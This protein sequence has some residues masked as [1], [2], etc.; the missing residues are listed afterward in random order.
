M[1]H[2]VLSQVSKH[3]ASCNILS[4]AQHG[5]RR[6][7]STTTQLTSTLHDWSSTIQKRSQVD[8]VFLDFQKAFDRVPHQ[9]LC[10]KLRYYGITGDTLN[11]IMSFLTNRQQ[12]VV[13]DGSKSTW[14]NVTSGVPQDD[15]D[16]IENET[17]DFDLSLSPQES[18]PGPQKADA[19]DDVCEDEEDEV[20]M[21]P[22]GFK[23]QCVAT[24]AE[25]AIAE[26]KSVSPPSAAQFALIF[27]EACSVALEFEKMSSKASSSSSAHSSSSGSGSSEV[28]DARGSKAA[29]DLSRVQGTDCNTE[30]SE[31]EEGLAHKEG[32]SNKSELEH[33][34]REV[35]RDIR[36][37]MRRA[38]YT[39]KTNQP[40]PYPTKP[41]SPMKRE[42]QREMQ[43]PSTKLFRPHPPQ[44]H[45]PSNG[46]GSML[47]M[48]R[49]RRPTALPRPA[50][51]GTQ[52][53]GSRNPTSHT[54]SDGPGS[55]I[56]VSHAHTSPA[57]RPASSRMSGLKK[58]GFS[59]TS[60]AGTKNNAGT[61]SKTNVQPKPATNKPSGLKAPGKK[62]SLMKPS[63][64][65]RPGQRNGAAHS[66]QTAGGAGVSK[67][68]PMRATMSF[69][70]GSSVAVAAA[71][72]RG[73]DPKKTTPPSQISA[74]TGKRKLATP[75][76]V[77]P[78]AATPCTP[79]CQEKKVVPKRLLSSG[80]TAPATPKRG[81]VT[82]RRST[83][84]IPRPSTPVQASKPHTRHSSITTPL[85]A[86]RPA[87]ARRMSA[88]P[89][90]G[91]RPDS[92]LKRCGST[93][94]IGSSVPRPASAQPVLGENLMISPL[95]LSP[96]MSP[97][98]FQL[99]P[100]P[101]EG[102]T[103]ET[104]QTSAPP[105]QSTSPECTI[106]TT[107]TPTPANVLRS[108]TNVQESETETNLVK[109][110]TPRN[111]PAVGLLV[112]F[113]SAT[114]KEKKGVKRP[115]QLAETADKENLITF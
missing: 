93:S 45:A 33:F 76:A 66:S 99:S 114:P 70:T 77:T 41:P 1:E 7:L 36:C 101:A 21:G 60:N 34:K 11:W 38:T 40:S 68:Q 82:P 69:G 80:S 43:P 91:R 62:L 13:V 103:K 49:L 18:H 31:T 22:V 104:T 83:S 73:K 29:T 79:V 47:P 28:K 90:P 59:K 111:A 94:K 55:Q 46:R 14:K 25:L 56:P 20:F 19:E 96:L 10:T 115:Q 86:A 87:S 44:T 4:D 88:I 16:L 64:I 32:T 5:F 37:P 102:V 100:E 9:R 30:P 24:N 75:R 89:T 105:T 67:L 54:S 57:K 71:P 108:R 42:P 106:A 78:R 112:D 97:P 85:S 17:F 3:L 110:A 58:P 2:I 51:G 92:S 95:Q 72:S 12:A 26:R 65:S 61:Q 53:N 8:A 109:N 113:S 52:S 35:K 15:F 107:K 98:Q 48:S 39:I 63:V 6:G 27:K 74:N 23:E 50:T 84:S 81:A